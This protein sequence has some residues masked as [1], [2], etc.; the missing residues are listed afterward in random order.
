MTLALWVAGLGCGILASVLAGG[1]FTA[2]LAIAAGAAAAAAAALWFRARRRS[3]ASGTALAAAAGA[4]LATHALESPALPAPIEAAVAAE[5]K[6]EVVAIVRRGPE[7]VAR[8]SRLLL[9]TKSIAGAPGV[10]RLALVVIGTE[11]PEVAPGDRIGFLAAVRRPAV[12]ANPDVPDP[13]IALR[14]EGIDLVAGVAGPAGI[15]RLG[16]GP[17]GLARPAFSAR[18][19]LGAA[20]DAQLDGGARAFLHTAVL[21]ERAGVAPEVEDGF[22][23]AGATHVLS[24]SGLHLGAVA[25]GVFL[26]FRALA[27]R[28]PR[29]PLWI[30]PGAAAAVVAVPT[31]AFYT[32]LT[33][34]AVATVRSALMATVVLGARMVGRRA[35]APPTLA[36]AAGV[37]LV[38]SPLAL[39]D[40]SFRLSFAS[41]AAL[42]GL[43]GRIA[44]E[45]RTRH[46]AA[47]LARWAGG[48]FAATLAA[49]VAT[50]PLCAHHFGEVT[51]AGLI[52]NLLLVPIVE[53]A[54]VPLG[55]GGALLGAVWAPLG[56]VPLAFAG[57]AAEAA[58]A[59][60]EVFRRLAP[61][62]LVRSPSV[63]ETALLTC[64]GGLAL[65]AAGRALAAAHRRRLLGGA[66]LCVVL[67]AGSLAAREISRRR[68]T[69]LR[70][71]FLD[72]G[73]GD[74]ALIEAPGGDALLI[75]GGG[76]YDGSFDPGERVVEPVLRARGITRLE[77]V[78]L[79]HP[80]P[81][82]MNGLARVLRR[83]EVGALWTSGDGGRNPEYG[84]LLE[85]ARA[86][87]VDLPV[88]RR[89]ALGPVAVTP[90]GPFV[91]DRIGAPPGLGVNDSSLSLR[92]A[93]AGR[94]LLFA[95]DLEADGEA[96]LAAR[97]TIGLPV[98]S[99]VLKVPHHGSR[100]SSTPELLDA[101]APRLAVF[102]LGRGN[103]FHFPNPGV[104]R[105]YRERGI[106]VLRT[107]LC[108]AVTVVVHADGAMEATPMRDCR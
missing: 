37:V 43:A 93:Y 11:P 5:A 96:E 17:G 59:V 3:G 52:G 33:G 99:E 81:D 1:G 68:S 64:A 56:V 72:V 60:A 104:V 27:S 39:F 105:R 95:G 24:V 50:A 19:A 98:A 22:R 62:L 82:H 88:P 40:V 74:A 30:D 13:L 102:S 49:T 90:C 6:V 71:T 69:D 44:P 28:V 54:V 51:P 61:V 77:V 84:R 106:D 45:G 35:S 101:V 107:D 47:R 26:M 48:L 55:L 66:A 65:A 73:Q 94:S 31:I 16:G 34:S 80:H 76:T 92:V 67:A 7:P 38:A 78:A 36:C 4:L 42:A 29:L 23:A 75:D 57:W 89:S 12:L 108:G 8:G 53:L 103:R 87:G 83:F 86:R 14:R 32:I 58:L 18:R 20:I 85:L 15:R 10:A 63:V 41:V 100:T 9:E 21:G 91:G 46:R 70:V 2:S 25:L 79:S 97:S